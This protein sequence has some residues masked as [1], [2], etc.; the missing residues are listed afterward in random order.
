M[1]P[2]CGPSC[3]SDPI[4]GLSCMSATR[5]ALVPSLWSLRPVRSL[6]D[7]RALWL[8]GRESSACVPRFV[9]PEVGVSD[10]SGRVEGVFTVHLVAVTFLSF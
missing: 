8:V 6:R 9:G 7:Q 3:A 10:R 1:P 2:V 5:Q 4:R